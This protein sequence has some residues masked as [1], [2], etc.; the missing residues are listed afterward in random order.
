MWGLDGENASVIPSSG[1]HGL[2]QRTACTIQSGALKN[3]NL[4][5]RN[6]TVRSDFGNDMD[7]NRLILSY[8]MPLW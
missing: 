8:S 6:A 3:L 1:G 4:K 5:W 2:R 7:E